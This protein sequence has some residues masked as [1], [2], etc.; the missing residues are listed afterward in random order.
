MIVVGLSHRSAP[1]AVRERLAVAPTDLPLRL[2]ELKQR[3]DAGEMLILSTCNRVEVVA[4]PSAPGPCSDSELGNRIADALESAAPGVRPHLYLR[5]ER[6]A[7][8]HL[9]RVACSLDA[10]VVGEPQILGQLKEAFAAA[11][12]AGTI[13]PWLNRAFEHAFRVAKRVRSETALGAGQVSIPTVAVDLAREIF[14][15]LDGHRVVL[16]GTGEIASLVATRLGRAGARL[17]V[18]GRTFERARAVAGAIGAEPRAWDDFPG[19][20]A[21]ADIV[22]SSTSERG[23]VITPEH[24]TQIWRQRHGRSLFLVDLAVPRDVD[25]RLAEMDGVFLYNVD[26]LSQVADA[27]LADRRHEAEKA[28]AIVAEETESYMRRAHAERI[29]PTLVA[30]RE[31]WRKVLEAELERSLRAEHVPL[32]TGRKEAVQRATLAAVEKLL[33]APTE[34]LRAWAKED[35]C[36]DWHTDLL[37]RAVEELF[38]LGEPEAAPEKNVKR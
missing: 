6:S 23:H 14:S 36:G 17:C 7:I 1:V 2:A 35:R 9:F 33:H 8:E 29:T 21:S 4:A 38:Q 28:D 25:P 16:V 5:E 19:L 24:V 37:V 10:M 26:D 27:A 31:H 11:R 12:S 34:R 32:E 30:L 20:L 3:V 18:V 22:V 15:E 13:G